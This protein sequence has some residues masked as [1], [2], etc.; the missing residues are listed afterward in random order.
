[1]VPKEIVMKPVLVSFALCPYVQRSVIT[2]KRKRAE[3]EIQYIDLEH[4][5]GWFEK[6]SPLGQVPV[7]LVGGG[8]GTEPTA[9][10][11]SAVINEYLDETIG[12]RLHPA[13]P[14]PRAKERAWI[15]YGSSLL[16]GQY[17][18]WM[19]KDRAALTGLLDEMFAD[20]ARLEPVLSSG[21]FFR[22][23]E[24]GLVDAAYAPYFMRLRL[25]PRVWDDAR[26]PRTPKVRAWAEA[27]LALPEVKESVP[28]EFEAQYRSF[29]KERGTLLLD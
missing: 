20:L 24:F 16:M 28:A 8:G 1:L 9:I 10:F 17:H 19:E 25:A 23:A 3:Y 7:L 11:E 5:P 18:L 26:W 14:L 22:G 12:P 27:L 13:D 15:E 4:P 29:A 21:P 2:L 6:V